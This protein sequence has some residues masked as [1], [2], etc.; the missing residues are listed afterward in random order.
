MHCAAIGAPILGDAAYG[1][2]RGPADPDRAGENTALVE[3]L[4]QQLHLHARRLVLPH[5]AGGMLAVEAPLPPHM[6][7][8][9]RTLGFA[10]PPPKPPRH[11]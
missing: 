7:A 10:A 9:F 4:G 5:P 11:G 3:G 8:T 2:A 1:T 6:E